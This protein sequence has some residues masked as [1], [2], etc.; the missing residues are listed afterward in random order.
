MAQKTKTEL[1]QYVLDFFNGGFRRKMVIFQVFFIDLLDSMSLG[2]G[3]TNP[4]DFPVEL[5][6]NGRLGGYATGDTVFQGVTGFQVFKKLLQIRILPVYTVPVVAISSTTPAI[7]EIGENITSVALT[8]TFSRGDAGALSSIRIKRGSNLVGLAG[9]ASP[10]S[11]TDSTGLIRS[12]NA[13][14]YAAEV[15]YAA[16]VVKQDNLL[17]DDTRSFG[18]G[19]NNPQAAGTVTANLSIIGQ[20]RIWFGAVA[21]EPTSSAQV[22][23]I[24]QNRLTGAGNTFSYQTGTIQ[25][26]FVIII[27]ATMSLVS[28]IDATNLNANITPAF[29]LTNISVN[30]ASGA[31][32]AYKKYTLTNSSPYPVD[33]THNVTLQ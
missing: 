21:A 32:V 31:A 13:V 27:P 4:A 33:S 2:G 11:R 16:G 29:V 18:A 25:K 19:P 17:Q 1:V 10:L 24:A 9:N 5:G 7:G 28:V 23:A 22:R 12:T 26:V 14:T 8:A 30:D 15:D 3:D 6:Q 20:Y